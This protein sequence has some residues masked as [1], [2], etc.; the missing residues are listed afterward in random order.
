MTRRNEPAP[1]P[2]I[3]RAVP[4]GPNACLLLSVPDLDPDRA[5]PKPRRKA[6]QAAELPLFVL[7]GRLAL[8]GGGFLDRA[9][10]L[11]GFRPEGLPFFA[12]ETWKPHEDPVPGRPAAAPFLLEKLS[13]VPAGLLLDNHETPLAMLAALLPSIFS[14]FRSPPL[15]PPGLT[16]DD[17]LLLADAIRARRL[18]DPFALVGPPAPP[19]A[20]A[21]MGRPRKT[22]TQGG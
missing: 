13:F 9:V 21:R 16:D 2:R 10:P 20:P 8:P 5:P 6:E 4:V 12:R 22:S 18:A 1:L 11:P 3:C 15:S 14:R 17:V 7:P 19:P